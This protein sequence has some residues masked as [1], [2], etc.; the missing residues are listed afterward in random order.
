MKNCLK[1]PL[2]E[3]SRWRHIRFEIKPRYLGNHA[4]QMKSY[5]GTRS[6]SH[7]HFFRI[8]PLM[9]SYPAWNKNIVLSE[10]IHPRQNISMERNQ[11]VMVALS[12][13][14]IKNRLKRSLAEKSR[15][16]HIRLTIKPR[17]SCIS[18][19]KLLWN[20]VRKSWSLFQNPVMKNRVERP[21][22]TSYPAWS[23]KKSPEAPPG[24][25]IMMT[26]NPVNIKTSLS[27]KPCIAD[28]K[29]T[30]ERYQEVMVAL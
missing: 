3:K 22:I 21:L 28:K 16:H 2:A 18:D 13:S 25:E 15:W 20:A 6:G 14:V 17:K 8:P 7:D 29:V 4:S 1:R 11:E 23:H 10:T 12:E 5:N 19:K 27:R 26:S 24:G 9:T 30:M